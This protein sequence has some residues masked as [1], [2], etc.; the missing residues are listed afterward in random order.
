MVSG[1][2]TSGESSVWGGSTVSLYPRESQRTEL[3]PMCVRT[4]VKSV[5]K[6]IINGSIAASSAWAIG[7]GLGEAL[8]TTV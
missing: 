8:E 3:C 2:C 6:T 4:D 1:T 5:V 7:L